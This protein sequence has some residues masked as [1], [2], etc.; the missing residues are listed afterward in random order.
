MVRR[1]TPGREDIDTFV[2]NII[3]LFNI[4]FLTEEHI[5]KKDKLK[6]YRNY[7]DGDEVKQ[8]LA[9]MLEDFVQKYYSNDYIRKVDFHSSRKEGLSNY[10]ELTFNVPFG[11]KEWLKHMKIRVSDHPKHNDRKIDEYIYVENKTVEQI[12]NQ[13]DNIV[14]KRIRRLQREEQGVG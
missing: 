5:T 6:K 2:E 1:I 7:E 14:N 9:D 12:E 13:L 3:S 8:E 10:I 4:S 11:S